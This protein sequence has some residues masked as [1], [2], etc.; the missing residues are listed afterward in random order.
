[1]ININRN[2]IRVLSKSLGSGGS[3]P[4][5]VFNLWKYKADNYTNLT[6][7]VAPTANEGE[8]AI[9]Y[10]S[11][12]IWILGTRKLKGYY[13]FQSGT[14]VYANQ[15]L[16]DKLRL[17]EFIDFDPQG[18][19]PAFLEGRVWYDDTNKTLSMYNDESESSL[20]IGQEQ[21]FRALNNTGATITNGLIAY[22]NGESGGTPT[23]A[24]AQ[25]DSKITAQSVIGAAT[26]DVENGTIG[27][28]TISGTIRD[29]DTSS[30]TAGDLIYLSADTPGFYTNV[31]PQSPNYSILLGVVTK[32][33]ATLGTGQVGIQISGNIGGVI[34]IFN[35][36]ILE[37]TTIDVV[38]DGVDVSV[39]LERQGGGD[40]D[41]F[42]NSG[43]QSFDATPKASVDL[44]EGTD[45]VP[46]INYVFIPQSTNVLTANTTGYPDVQLAKIGKFFIKSA[47]SVQADGCLMC[48]P[49]DDHLSRSSTNQGHL[50]HINRW[51]EEQ[52]ATWISPGVLPSVDITV[53]A[54]SKDNVD[55][56]TT[57]GQVL[58]L[59]QNTFPAKDTSVDD[60]YIVN[61]FTTKFNK[62]SDLNEIA[63]IED[64][65]TIS[66]NQI[67]NLVIF[68]VS[69]S[70]STETK[71]FLNLPNGTYI[72]ESGAIND[73]NKTSNFNI[74]SDFKGAGFLIARITLKFNS[75]ANGT[76]TLINLEDLRGKFPSTIAGSGNTTSSIGWMP[77]SIPLGSL[78]TSGASFFVN[79][80]AGIYLSM[81]G[82][83]D[84]AFFF[85]DSLNKAGSLYDGSDIALKIHCRISSNGGVGDDVGLLLDY[86]I[87]KD[88]DNTSTTVTNVAQVDYDVSGE[89]QDEE[90]DIILTTMTGVVGGENAMVTVTRN[91]TGAG[92]DSYSGN[93]EIISLEWVII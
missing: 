32:S 36:A 83:S 28:F 89:I 57:L 67:Y 48:F 34:K 91:S 51:I 71:L 74:P 73:L 61:D 5:A 11:Q 39:T 33:H 27:I 37:D 55:F 88:G 45:T 40:L 49:Q 21:W 60:I 17:F 93:F 84:D 58:Q 9:V 10:N 70:D 90:F 12:G 50:S 68:G 22:V 56:I 6:T 13:M 92:A 77:N 23:V 76:Y 38:S 1:M 53:N 59:H 52:N 42:F 18:T 14:W 30:F 62:I 69:S 26:H 7:V 43:F 82:A 19:P 79:A 54:G 85:N 16:Q 24:L 78:L 4:S 20:Q 15:E 80:G 3:D 47:A 63:T 29:V 64:G 25:A 86:A 87:V 65:T 46:K 81:S 44:T 35:G 2:S 8:L 72:S 66:N 41:L 31:E 75:A